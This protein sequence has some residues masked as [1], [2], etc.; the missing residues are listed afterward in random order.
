MEP[1][2]VNLG[3]LFERPYESRYSMLRRCLSANPGIPLSAIEVTLRRVVPDRGSLFERVAALQAANDGDGASPARGRSPR[4]C[5]ACAAALYH[6][7]VYALPWLERCPIHHCAFT[8]C[9]PVCAR[10]WPPW[11]KLAARDC[12]HCGCVPF[13][14][15]P[16]VIAD[17][18]CSPIGEIHRFMRETGETHDLLGLPGRLPPPLIDP[19]WREI[20]LD[21]PL[22]GAFQAHRCRAFRADELDALHIRRLP[23]AHR[24]TR[25]SETDPTLASVMPRASRNAGPS[26]PP[27]SVLTADYAVTRAIVAW[28]SRRAP[29]H[30]PHVTSYRHLRP[31]HLLDGPDPCPQCMALSLW[32]F[33]A[34]ARH[35]AP[36]FARQLEAYPFYEQAQ[37]PEPAPIWWPAVRHEDGR[38]SYPGSGF[39]AWLIRRQLESQF[40]VLYRFLN[41]WCEQLRHYRENHDAGAF[42]RA[43]AQAVPPDH[44]YA[45]AV[46][47]ERLT[48]Y[49][50]GE[51]PLDMCTVPTG[52]RTGS[53]CRTFHRHHCGP[54]AG[55][56]TA[57]DFEIERDG[58]P[59]EAFLELHKRFRQFLTTTVPFPGIGR[60]A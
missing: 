28:L 25:L 13:E 22:Y 20:S 40:V 12:P 36:F 59:Y 50:E 44:W 15:L 2:L 17:L 29:R 31:E 30:R 26:A 41:E 5:P 4:Q 43:R 8:E 39:R 16:D 21:S 58:L 55:V 52:P 54:N 1:F 47:G 10:P 24:T 49:Y 18:D 48:F 33:R 35:Y 57:F 32:F 27:R 7:D 11:E 38:V 9:C 51:H 60:P 56:I 46:S 23:L 37:G 45:S 34:A 14:R 53:R 3:R 19:A 42:R 6:S